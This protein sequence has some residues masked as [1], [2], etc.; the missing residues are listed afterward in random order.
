MYVDLR[1]YFP[2][3]ADRH[4]ALVGRTDTCCILT[5]FSARLL[6]FCFPCMDFGPKTL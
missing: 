4:N 2:Y 3:T 5:L 6:G 1:S